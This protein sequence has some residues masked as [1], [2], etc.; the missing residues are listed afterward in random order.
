[1]TLTHRDGPLCQIARFH[2]NAWSAFCRGLN[3][4]FFKDVRYPKADRNELLLSSNGA[5]SVFCLI[6]KMFGAFLNSLCSTPT[7]WERRDKPASWRLELSKVRWIVW[8]GRL[9]SPLITSMA[10]HRSPSTK[11]S[12]VFALLFVGWWFAVRLILRGTKLRDKIWETWRKPSSTIVHSVGGCYILKR[13]AGPTRWIK[14][15]F[16]AFY[17]IYLTESLDSATFR[18][19]YSSG[20]KGGQGLYKYR[21]VC[22]AVHWGGIEICGPE[23]LMY[24][25]FRFV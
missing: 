12:N 21:A 1:M 5:L 4:P 2:R 16:P 6:S 9:H 22:Q 8:T 7:L 14:Y 20:R 25:P 23:C 15:V 18:R 11:L 19:W 13:L 24:S 17:T 3:L 10:I